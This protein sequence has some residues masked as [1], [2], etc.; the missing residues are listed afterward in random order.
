MNK[1]IMDLLDS[2]HELEQNL[3]V[4]MHKQRDELLYEFNKGR[5]VFNREI[6]ERNQ[7]LKIGIGKYLMNARWLVILTAPIIYSLI[8]P[9]VVLDIF[10]TIYQ[11]ICFPV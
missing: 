9:F 7:A 2:I 4:E 5:V 10:V 6:K 8:L 11:T 1:N 3:A